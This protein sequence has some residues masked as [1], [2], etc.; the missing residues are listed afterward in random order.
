[1]KPSLRAALSSVSSSAR[2][3]CGSNRRQ[4]IADR[5]ESQYHCHG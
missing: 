5:H 3:R 1:M 2:E 4:A